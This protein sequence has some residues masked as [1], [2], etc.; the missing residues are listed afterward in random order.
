MND[1]FPKLFCLNNSANDGVMADT[2]AN[3]CMADSKLH[4][5]NCCNIKPVHISLALKSSGPA[6]HYTCSCMGYL[7]TTQE[8]G[9][10]CHQLFLVNKNASDTTK[11]P[12]T[13]MQSCPDFASYRRKVSMMVLLVFWCSTIQLALSSS[14]L[15]SSRRITSTTARV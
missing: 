6:T 10:I 8:G 1:V 9:L 4:L 15:P 11:S 5:V 7:P 2:G 12:Q 3:S 13:I 14:G